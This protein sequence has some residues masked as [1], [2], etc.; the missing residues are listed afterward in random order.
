MEETLAS[1][2]MNISHLSFPFLANAL[3]MD[4]DNISVGND[5]RKS[6]SCVSCVVS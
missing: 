5:E 3:K 1:N 2:I 4:S 6:C